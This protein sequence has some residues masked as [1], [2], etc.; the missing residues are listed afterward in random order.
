MLPPLRAYIH[1]WSLCLNK[2]AT[3]SISKWMTQ[4]S[5]TRTTQQPQ[6]LLRPACRFR[7]QLMEK[8]V[9]WH[10]QWRALSYLTC[11]HRPSLRQPRDQTSQTTHTKLTTGIRTAMLHR[12]R[13]LAIISCSIG[14]QT[15]RKHKAYSHGDRHGR[16]INGAVVNTSRRH[17]IAQ[18]GHECRKGGQPWWFLE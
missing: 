16:W 1:H 11:L 8:T 13:A 18:L 7:T 17:R 6:T 4:I 12:L 5:G 10:P 2:P 3:P 9:T 15:F 14:L